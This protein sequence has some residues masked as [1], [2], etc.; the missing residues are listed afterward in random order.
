MKEQLGSLK[1]GFNTLIKPSYLIEF[2]A[3]ELEH[4]VC[5]TPSID[6]GLLK[7]RAEYAG[8]NTKSEQIQ[9]LWSCLEDFSQ[10]R[11]EI[12]FSVW[13]ILCVYERKKYLIY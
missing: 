13:I 8:Y 12:D 2:D 9:W 4:I 10:V 1:E 11:C 7:K 6:I 3:H 5:G